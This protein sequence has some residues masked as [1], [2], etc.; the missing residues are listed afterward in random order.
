MDML[1]TECDAHAGRS[2]KTAVP[3]SYMPFSP[4]MLF[5]RGSMD[6]ILCISHKILHPVFQTVSAPNKVCLF[7]NGPSEMAG[8]AVASWSF[9]LQ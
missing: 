9:Q 3:F 5:W 6:K 1:E 2:K 8:A 7:L 4:N